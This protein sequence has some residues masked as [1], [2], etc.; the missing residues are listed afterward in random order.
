MY[1]GTS[2]SSVAN[3]TTI[4]SPIRRRASLNTQNM[5]ASQNTTARFRAI[6]NPVEWKKPWIRCVVDK[7]EE[8]GSIT[9]EKIPGPP[10]A[11]CRS[12][13]RSRR[14]GAQDRTPRAAPVA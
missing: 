13:I 3:R 7:A 10:P 9:E 5:S 12:S 6:T 11:K 4:G 1:G 14:G 8:S 2:P